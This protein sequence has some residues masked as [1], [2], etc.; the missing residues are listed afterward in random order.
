M[1]EVHGPN[2]G[3]FLAG[4]SVHNQRIER[5]WRDVFYTVSYFLLHISGHGR[6]RTPSA[7]QPFAQVCATLHFYPQN[8]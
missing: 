4:T 5:L 2:R 7:K 1:E 6:I 8:K 3:S